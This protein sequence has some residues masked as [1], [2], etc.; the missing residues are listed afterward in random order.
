MHQQDMAKDVH[1]KRMKEMGIIND[2]G[3]GV[4][5][6]SLAFN[7]GEENMEKK[8]NEKQKKHGDIVTFPCCIARLFKIEEFNE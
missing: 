7:D 1:V 2:E 4:N 6:I 5:D 8:L 3:K